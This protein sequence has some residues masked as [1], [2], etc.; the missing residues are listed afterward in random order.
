[1]ILHLAALLLVNKP[2]NTVVRTQQDDLSAHI[3]TANHARIQRELF[4]FGVRSLLLPT[5]KRLL[6]S[7]RLLREQ[8]DQLLALQAGSVYRP[9]RLEYVRALEGWTGVEWVSAG[10]ASRGTFL[11]LRDGGGGMEKWVRGNAAG[12]SRLAVAA[13]AERVEVAHL[14]DAWMG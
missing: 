3:L 6:V 2:T 11:K 8:I 4:V 14:A 7:T 5:H 1:M 9:Q 12:W 10:K 13:L